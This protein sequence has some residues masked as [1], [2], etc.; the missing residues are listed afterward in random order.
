MKILYLLPLVIL[1]TACSTSLKQAVP[2]TKESKQESSYIHEYTRIK[3]TDINLWWQRW[4]DPSLLVLLKES[5]LNNENS[6]QANKTI[7]YMKDKFKLQVPNPAWLEKAISKPSD[8]KIL[9]QDKYWY[10]ARTVLTTLLAKTYVHLNICEM[11]K[12]SLIKLEETLLQI[13][14]QPVSPTIPNNL[15]AQITET[16]ERLK[17]KTNECN[18][19]NKAL[20]YISNAFPKDYKS[21]IERSKVQ[22][23]IYNNSSAFSF[24]DEIE[25]NKLRG[26]ADVSLALYQFDMKWKGLT[27]SFDPITIKGTLN[28]QSLSKP[29]GD[30]VFAIGSIAIHFPITLIEKEAEN[31]DLHEA[32]NHVLKTI[33]SAALDVYES[34][35]EGISY[36]E[37]VRE[38]L[39]LE[40]R[41]L[42][43]LKDEKDNLSDIDFLL[44]FSQYIQSAIQYFNTQEKSIDLW[45]N[46]YLTLGIGFLDLP[47][48]DSKP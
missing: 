26:R 35:S 18:D 4:N 21:I 47:E 13:K 12:K 5:S 37:K 20:L 22:S 28:P 44:L 24:P 1:T 30:N 8:Y 34:L 38:S 25:A 14:E 39:Q 46:L 43:A 2:V 31:P 40:K 16:K 15:D 6:A 10:D 41:L 17:N 45:F 3:N 23:L 29:Q 19:I 7:Q 36:S 33:Q 9:Y 27:K 48:S 32:R 11:N 42:Y